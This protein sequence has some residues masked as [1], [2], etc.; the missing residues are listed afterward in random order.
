[1]YLEKG[2][3]VPRRAENIEL[4]LPELKLIIPIPK[5][6]GL[7][8]SKMI[9]FIYTLGENDNRFNLPLWHVDVFLSIIVDFLFVNSKSQLCQT[10]KVEYLL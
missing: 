10:V 5:D 4:S 7:I 8:T 9:S 3:S 1:M 6:P 2:I